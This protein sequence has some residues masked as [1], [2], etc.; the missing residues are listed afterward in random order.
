M[1]AFGSDVGTQNPGIFPSVLA[2]VPPAADCR[3]VL[4][5]SKISAARLAHP[6]RQQL[7]LDIAVV[8]QEAQGRSRSS[9]I[10]HAGARSYSFV[11]PES[12]A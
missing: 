1:H 3:Q 11:H 5:N 4:K 6:P 10:F 9:S 8:S 12:L 2:S 7:L